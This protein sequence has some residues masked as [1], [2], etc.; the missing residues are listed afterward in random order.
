MNRVHSHVPLPHA[1][2]RCPEQSRTPPER[3]PNEIPFR[4][5]TSAVLR[6]FI[7]TDPDPIRARLRSGEVFAVGDAV[8]VAPAAKRAKF[9]GVIVVMGAHHAGGR[10]RTVQ[11]AV[12][13]SARNFA[14]LCPLSALTRTGSTSALSPEQLNAAAERF[15]TS[16]RH[17]GPRPDTNRPMPK[18]AIVRL[19]H[20][21]VRRPVTSAPA[22]RRVTGPL[23]THWSALPLICADSPRMATAILSRSHSILVYSL[24]RDW[25]FVT[26]IGSEG[27]GAG[28]FDRPMGMCVYRG[29]LI[30]CDRG[31]N[32]LQFIDISAADAKDW[33]FDAPFVS[34]G[35]AKGQF[36]AAAD[37]C[38]A[39]GVLFVADYGGDRVQTF[40]IAVDAATDAVTLTPRSIIGGS[41]SPWALACAPVD[42]SGVFVADSTQVSCIDVESDVV[43]PFVNI[44][45]A[46]GICLADGL[47]YCARRLSVRHPCRERR[48]SAV[49]CEDAAWSIVEFCARG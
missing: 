20:R 43:R 41:A 32:R 38:E 30:V 17:T 39:G 23:S 10:G 13:D 16:H 15:L 6:Q 2:E 42:A 26:A 21:R 44:A 47:L 11:A 5:V 24:E 40:A 8:D 35:T 7:A 1:A 37:V 22:A 45:S 49:R 27:K 18:A 46:D 12:L 25:A 33:R 4:A 19:P 28:Q 3:V 31:N 36:R 14:A 48:H 29:R 9:S 34:E